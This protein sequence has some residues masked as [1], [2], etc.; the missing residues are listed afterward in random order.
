MV[1]FTLEPIPEPKQRRMD[2]LYMDL[3]ARI[4]LSRKWARFS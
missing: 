2:T 1:A 4:G 3:A